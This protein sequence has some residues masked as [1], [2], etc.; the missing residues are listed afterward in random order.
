MGASRDRR[1]HPAGRED[2]DLAPVGFLR[3]DANAARQIDDPHEEQSCGCLARLQLEPVE[4]LVAIVEPHRTGE[5]SV[6]EARP[7]LIEPG[8][9]KRREERTESNVLPRRVRALRS[10]IGKR[11]PMR[12]EIFPAVG[13]TRMINTVSDRNVAPVLIAP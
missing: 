9:V 1:Q 6:E 5:E 2:R 13:A 4:Q 7:R 10:V 3:A 8:N 12:S 11:G